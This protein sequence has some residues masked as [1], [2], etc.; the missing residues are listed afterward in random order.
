MLPPANELPKRVPRAVRR[1][2]LCALTTLLLLP[3]LGA[4][5]QNAATTERRLQQ[6]RE[7]LRQT[8]EQ[9]KQGE[10]RMQAAS[11]ALRRADAEV[12]SAGRA[13]A[14]AESRLQATTE[15]LRELSSQRTALAARVQGHRT[16]L[17]A[18]L[19]N[20]HA[21][22]SQS[23]LKLLLSQDDLSDTQRVLAYSR[24][25]QQQ[26]MRLLA[27]INADLQQ[28]QV[29]EEQVQAQQTVLL[30]QRDEQ[31]RLN[32]NLLNRRRSQQAEVARISATQS[33]LESRQQSLQRDVRALE[34]VLANLRAQASRAQAQAQRR[35]PAATRPGATS[36]P[37]RGNAGAQVAAGMWPLSGRMIRRYGASLGDGRRSTGVL[38]EAANGTPVS[39]VADGKVVYSDWM[40]GYGMIL[41]VDHGNGYMTLYAHNESLL[42]DTGS[43]VRRGETIARVGSSGGQ[44]QPAL[45]FEV[46]R[47]GQPV[48]P[49]SWLRR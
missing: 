34:T 14:E 39:A 18:L 22:G 7:Q 10:A 28:A 49:A 2:L 46:R 33:Q 8:A 24:Y 40:T 32:A 13:L 42:S 6:S 16:Q 45:Y 25:L 12:A 27:T 43:R 48:D 21:Q 31:R 29:L 36:P 23:A 3:V 5:A 41:I 11:T 37:P 15:Q 19:R 4:Q 9:R 26:Q 17:A 47:N 44:G 38:I 1:G 20:S 35:P 30:A